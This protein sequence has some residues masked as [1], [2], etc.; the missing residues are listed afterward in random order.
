MWICVIQKLLTMKKKLAGKANHYK[1]CNVVDLLK[2]Q[3]NGTKNTR[4]S[5]CQ[6]RWLNPKPKKLDLLFSL[7]SWLLVQQIVLK[8]SLFW[9]KKQD[10]L[11]LLRY[12]LWS[13]KPNYGVNYFILTVRCTCDRNKNG[14]CKQHQ[15]SIKSPLCF[16]VLISGTKCPLW[17]I[18]LIYCKVNIQQRVE[19]SSSIQNYCLW[20]VYCLF[21]DLDDTS[22]W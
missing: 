14:K 11:Y 22:L 8:L 5:S 21:F 16:P 13:Q 12:S 9:N 1:K 7:V 2:K 18:I 15:I 17:Y 19:W 6:F 20:S 4:L 10:N 3:T